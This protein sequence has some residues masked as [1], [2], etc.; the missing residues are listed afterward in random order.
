[1]V[2]HLVEAARAGKEV[3]VVVELMA[4]FDEQNNLTTAQILQAAG[5]HVVYGM[6]GKK[7]H[8]KM[9]MIVRREGKRLKRYVH[10]GTGNYH[11]GNTRV[12]T[13]YGLLTN[14]S[15][16]SSDVHELFLQLTTQSS[17]H[18]LKKLHQSPYGI[19][20]MLVEKINR[21][22]QNASLGKVS[23]IIAKVNG[24]SSSVIINALYAASQAGVEIKLVVR[25]ICCLRPGLENI[26]ENIEVRSVVGR[27]LE[28]DRV[29]Y[30]EN[31][32]DES[33]LF[34]SSADLMPRNLRNRIE[35][36]VPIEDKRLK[37]TLYQQLNYYLQDNSHAWLLQADGSYIKIVNGGPG[38]E[39]FCAQEQLLK[40]HSE[41]Y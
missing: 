6:V 41:D 5:A 14:R 9:L 17:N 16:I 33:E 40:D 11:Q 22:A 18:K 12:Y 24:L 23:K 4:R 32:D 26:S 13:D 20:D 19:S 8:A 35:Q 7:T 31:G 39:K 25:G 28:H 38:E 3:T 2:E 36:C 27:F 37:K 30:F 10:L 29:F 34:I 1:L 15:D 21:E